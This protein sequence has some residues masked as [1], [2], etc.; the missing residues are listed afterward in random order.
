MLWD[1]RF[2]TGPL[3]ENLPSI[4]TLIFNIYSGSASTRITEVLMESSNWI[5]GKNSKMKHDF[6]EFK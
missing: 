4:G 5:D 1:F 6:N 3:S 2:K